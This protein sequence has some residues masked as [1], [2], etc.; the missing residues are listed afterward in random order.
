MRK[1]LKRKSLDEYFVS[2]PVTTSCTNHTLA[3]CEDG[4]TLMGLS[5]ASPGIGVPLCETP[6]ATQRKSEQRET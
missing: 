6:S 3:G 1:T 5:G 4:T 2:V